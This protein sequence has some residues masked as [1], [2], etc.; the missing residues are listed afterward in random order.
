M[1]GTTP[2]TMIQPRFMNSIHSGLGVHVDFVR[3]VTLDEWT[4][5][6][7]D[8]MKAGGND[9]CNA[10][11]EEHN[12]PSDSTL[13]ERYTSDIANHYKKVVAAAA[14]GEAPPP[15]PTPAPA[16]EKS[17]EGES[18]MSLEK[19]VRL[20]EPMTYSKAYAPYLGFLITFLTQSLSVPTIGIPYVALGI[21]TYFIAPDH[22]FLRQV[23][24]TSLVLP[25]LFLLG[26]YAFA[27]RMYIKNR[28]P[29][30]KSAQNLLWERIQNDR[31]K[32]LEGYDIYL[33]PPE[34]KESAS[35]KQGIIFFPGALV[36]QTA[37]SPVAAKLSDA[38]IL[39]V[40]MSLEP[41]RIAMDV[42]SCHKRA[43]LVMYEVLTLG[44]DISVDEWSLA[45]HSAGATMA[46]VL[47][48]KM[49]P[50][51]GKLI[52]CGIARDSFGVSPNFKTS[53]TQVLIM[54]GS[55]DP[56]VQGKTKEQWQ[57]FQNLLPPV[58]EEKDAKAAKGGSEYVTIEGGNHSGFAHYGPQTYP[59]PDGVRKITM[60]EQQDA[61]V[62]K[63]VEFLFA[64]SAE[65]GKKK[66]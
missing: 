44:L 43:L 66:D 45:G 7:S 40:V 8:I 59:R 28:Q 6:Q 27:L 50:G 57:E 63:T 1:T 46:L 65:Q 56:F 22:E 12:L 32:R 14:K 21:S 64:T 62:Q 39:V 61:F 35:P 55:E 29:A 23:W 19:I 5:D 16:G 3:S 25:P 37:Y 54:N 13:K 41:T 33:P 31:A 58:K 10:F 34:K 20:D 52:M 60:E 11:F 36:S 4:T 2:F 51:I 30:F 18:S 26:L 24:L 42:S 47:A 15:A 9:K 49:A 48:S 17:A 38:G 53:P